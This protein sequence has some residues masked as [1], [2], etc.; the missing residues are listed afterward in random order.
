MAPVLTI[1]S[2]PAMDVRVR[3]GLNASEL[4]RSKGLTQEEVAH[5]AAVNQ[6]YLSDIER[7]KRNPSLLVL[8]RIA[9]ALA[10]DPVDLLR[11]RSPS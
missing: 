7:G 10:A 6:T 9:Q 5:R 11:K 2:H 3:V 8:D 4:R 1:A